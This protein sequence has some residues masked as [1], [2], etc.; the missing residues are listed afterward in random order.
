MLNSQKRINRKVRCCLSCKVA[1]KRGEGGLVTIVPYLY[2]RKADGMVKAKP[3][4]QCVNCFVLA[5]TGYDQPEGRQLHNAVFESLRSSYNHIA[6]LS[7]EAADSVP[8][9]ISKDQIGFEL[10]VG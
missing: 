2:T 4:I 3:I 8:P 6:E 10:E 1:K 9:E 7:R 5:L